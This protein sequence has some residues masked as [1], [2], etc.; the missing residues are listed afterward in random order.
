MT[1]IKN[2]ITSPK[3]IP[4]TAE[5]YLAL[6]TEREKLDLLRPEVLQRLQ[7]ARE[8]GDLS[9][10]GAYKA[11]R[12]ELGGIDRRLRELS[13]LIILAR[14][15]APHQTK[16]VQF[17]CLITL[18]NDQ[19]SF[20]FTLVNSFESDPSNNKLSEQSPFGKAVLNHQVGDEVVVHSP[21]GAINFVIKK[22]EFPK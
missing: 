14:V 19:R 2:Q 5:G 10:N 3:R 8:M 16:T 21:S 11:A 22:I 13:R 20:T 7:T 18:T 17:G 1:K 9:E 4:F 12:W 15:T 6:K